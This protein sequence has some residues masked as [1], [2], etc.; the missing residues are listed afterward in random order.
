MTIEQSFVTIVK[1]KLVDAGYTAAKVYPG[2][3]PQSADYPFLTYQ[4][5]AD[6]RDRFANFTDPSDMELTTA[7]I[8]LQVFSTT[9]SERADII[10]NLRDVLHGYRG[11]PSNADMRSCFIDSISHFSENDLTG[12]DEQIYRA[13]IPFDISYIL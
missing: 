1:E 11:N 2:T 4:L 6:R 8:D 7:R 5:I 10:D 9:A 3:A 13:V 12:T